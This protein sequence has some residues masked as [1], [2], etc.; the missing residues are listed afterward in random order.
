MRLYSDRGSISNLNKSKEV[1]EKL[2][3]WEIRLQK[4]INYAMTYRDH[5]IMKAL[6]FI[7]TDINTSLGASV[8]IYRLKEQIAEISDKFSTIEQRKNELEKC[9]NTGIPISKE[10]QD[11]IAKHYPLRK[12]ANNR[13]FGRTFWRKS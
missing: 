5:G 11:Y 9:F 13:K 6:G 4:I 8:A 12:I 3:S 2:S 10:A 1:V 7:Y